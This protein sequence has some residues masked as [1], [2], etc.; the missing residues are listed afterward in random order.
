MKAFVLTVG[1][2]LL[3]SCSPGN[4]PTSGN[5]NLAREMF[6]AF[7]QH[8][9]NTM[10]EFYAVDAKFLDPSLGTDFVMQ[11]HSQTVSKYSGLQSI[12]PDVKDHITGVYGSGEKVI[13]EFVSTGTSA[14]GVQLRLP[15]VSVLTFKNG[16]II[17]DATYYDLENP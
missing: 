10:S 7:N 1:L 3:F 8:D 4:D 9:W 6:D 11:T 16:L 5:V 15:I 2:V 12:F 14:N 13:I 17:K